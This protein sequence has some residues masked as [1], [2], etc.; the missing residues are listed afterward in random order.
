MAKIEFPETYENGRPKWN[1]LLD[2]RMGTVDRNQKCLSCQENMNDCPGHFAHLELCK[3]M[4]HH[5]F[6]VRVSAAS[7]CLYCHSHTFCADKE[8]SRVHLCFMRQDKDG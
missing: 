5:G 1:G 7:S 8:D 6:M 2:P 3:P 4:F